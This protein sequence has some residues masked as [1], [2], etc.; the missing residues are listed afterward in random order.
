MILCLMKFDDRI[1]LIE[2]EVNDITDT[3]TSAFYIDLH[4]DIDSDV[5]IKNLILQQWRT[6]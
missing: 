4:L 3:Y 2:L 1:Y 5:G 6:C